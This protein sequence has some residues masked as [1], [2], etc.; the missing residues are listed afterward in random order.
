MRKIWFCAAVCLLLSACT[1]A[2]ETAE[3]D[4]AA[5]HAPIGPPT[6]NERTESPRPTEN[7]LSRRAEAL[8]RVH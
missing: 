4:A 7:P 2:P 8:W 3:D 1:G 6:I 5:I